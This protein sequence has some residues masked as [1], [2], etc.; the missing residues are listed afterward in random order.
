LQGTGTDDLRPVA[1]ESKRLNRAERNHSARDREQLALVHATQ[2][3]RH[4]LL[5]SPVTV[6][7]DHR[8]LLYPL[9]LEFMKSRHHRWEEQLNQ[10]DVHLTYREGRLN[11]VPDALSRRPD[12]KPPPP[13]D[14]PVL[15]VVS[16]LTPDPKFLTSVRSAT[17]NNPYAQ[18]VISR[19]VFADT[20]FESFSFDDGLL[21]NSDRLYIPPVP[22][23]RTL[24][25]HST[26]DCDV[27]GHLGQD[28]SYELN[29]PSIGQICKRDVPVLHTGLISCSTGTSIPPKVENPGSTSVDG[30]RQGNVSGSS[31]KG[32]DGSKA[33]PT[34]PEYE[35][36][37][38]HFS[39]IALQW[40]CHFSG[41]V[42]RR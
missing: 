11:T 18:M 2:K 28:K 12:H 6:R 16:S 17:A 33:F 25:L 35:L 7:T 13:S 41:S 22:E 32:I 8:P 39:G 42:S 37:P 21:Y 30:S 4:Y 15:A 14:Q 19:M 3:R 31:R 40:H 10:F 38:S 5:G 1:F 20:E 36:R 29:A 34:C 26:H 24:V 27:S 23:L 9:R